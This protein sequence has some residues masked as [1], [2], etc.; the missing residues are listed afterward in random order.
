M[1]VS[2]VESTNLGHFHDPT[3]C[4]RLGVARDRRVFVDCQVDSRSVVQV[5]NPTPIKLSRVKS[6]IR[7]TRGSV[8]LSPCMGCPSGMGSACV[9]AGSR[10]SGIVEP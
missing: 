2:M 3:E 6:V 8:V 1:P 9:G 4:E 7:G 10:R 5:D